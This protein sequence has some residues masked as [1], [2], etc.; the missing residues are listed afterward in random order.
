MYSKYRSNAVHLQLQ[1]LLNQQEIFRYKLCYTIPVLACLAYNK[2]YHSTEIRKKQSL[3][4]H[5]STT[6]G[7]VSSTKFFHMY[8]LG[9]ENVSPGITVGTAVVKVK[10]KCIYT[11]HFS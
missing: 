4:P 6:L 8:W 1:T 2:F 7:F 3:L 5:N 10:S 9:P 11:S